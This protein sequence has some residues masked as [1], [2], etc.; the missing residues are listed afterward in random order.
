MRLAH[1]ELLSEMRLAHSELLSE[2]Q[3]AHL[4]VM[5]PGVTSTKVHSC[6]DQLTQ[7]LPIHLAED[8]YSQMHFDLGI[9]QLT[10]RMCVQT[11][12]HLELP[13]TLR[14]RSQ[15]LCL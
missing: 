15:A 8:C 13:Q 6:R 14:E 11:W 3:L 12:M 9:K 10:T 4:N 5:L 1:S 2:M 7:A